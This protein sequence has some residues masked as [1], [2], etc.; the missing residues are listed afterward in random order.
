MKGRLFK[1]GKWFFFLLVAFFLGRFFYRNFDDI[2]ALDLTPDWPLFL[3]SI[4]FY[5]MYKLSQGWLWHYLTVQNRSAIPFSEGTRAYLYSH[6]GK[7]IPGKVFIVLARIPPYRKYG[8]PAKTVTVCFVL[9]NICTILSAGLL[10]II[11]LFV[12]PNETFN[13]YKWV[14]IILIIVFFICL[15][16]A[17]MNFFLG[18]LEKITRR[19]G[20]RV[21][22]TYR[23]MVIAVLL[24][25]L[26]WVV[27]G[28]GFYF[29]ACAFHPVPA[30]QWLYVVGIYSLSCI[31]GIMAIFSPSG[32]GVREGIILLGMGLIMDQNYAAVISI[33]ARL[34]AVLTELV[35]LGIIFVISKCREKN[36]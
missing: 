25:V 33:I 5:C 6:L 7:Y 32:L 3:L 21:R 26:N 16:P 24:F 22:I 19:E 18:L 30:G 2:R 20:F 36:K 17:I 29:L 15:N 9:E 10:F 4:V 35:L 28:T 31:A 34:W 11:S 23:Q 14:T 12:F 27:Y 8:V 13:S 1:A